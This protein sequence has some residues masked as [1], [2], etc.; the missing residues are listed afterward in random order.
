[1][2]IQ[3]ITIKKEAHFKYN[4]L[5][6]KTGISKL[7]KLTEIKDWMFLQKFILNNINSVLKNWKNILD[8]EDLE[9]FEN[10][11]LC[12]TVEKLNKRNFLSNSIIKMDLIR[13]FN[14]YKNKLGIFEEFFLLNKNTWDFDLKTK[15][16]QVSKLKLNK[17]YII[18]NKKIIENIREDKPISKTDNKELEDIILFFKSNDYS[19]TDLFN[20]KN[21]LLWLSNKNFIWKKRTVLRQ[22]EKMSS[23]YF[24]IF[25]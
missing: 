15:K 9:D 12:H 8:K 11:F 19:E 6:D 18:T 16:E 20:L 13:E 14:L 10:Y 3:I 25:L 7:L 21:Y 17:D 4:N 2:K 24:N 5:E 23:H 1:M 22:I